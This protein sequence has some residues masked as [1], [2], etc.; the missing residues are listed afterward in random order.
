[1]NLCIYSLCNGCD[2]CLKCFS[3]S[4]FLFRRACAAFLPPACILLKF[5]LSL[6]M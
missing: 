2:G 6:F 4:I 1:M 3:G 5:L